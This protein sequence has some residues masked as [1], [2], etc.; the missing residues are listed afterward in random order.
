MKYLYA[1]LLIIIS[2]ACKKTDIE[3]ES[4][5]FPSTLSLSSIKQKSKIRLFSNKQEIT[6]QKVIDNFLKGFN[7]FEIRDTSFVSDENLVFLTADSASIPNLFGSLT[8]LKTADQFLFK[9]TNIN[10]ITADQLTHYKMAKYQSEIDPVWDSK[11]R[12]YHMLI[13]YGDYS[14]LKLSVFNYSLTKWYNN[15]NDYFG[16][17][18]TTYTGYTY[19]SKT[20]GKVFNE[21][22]ESYLSSVGKSDTLAIQE[23]FYEFKKK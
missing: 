19:K 7:N 11:Y 14:E 22:N 12:F 23:Y 17:N 15:S 4:I 21:F 9:S 16:F 20:S 10:I 6:D 1:C 18:D 3:K 13:G 8:V 5:Q 2:L